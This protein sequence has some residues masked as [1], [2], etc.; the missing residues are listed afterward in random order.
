[1]GR[2]GIMDDIFKESNTITVKIKDLLLPEEE[3]EEGIMAGDKVYISPAFH[4]DF[5]AEEYVEAEHGASAVLV[6]VRYQNQLWGFDDW[7]NSEGERGINIAH[8][9]PLQQDIKLF[10][11]QCKT[12]TKYSKRE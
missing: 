1:M 9:E 4:M 6:V 10:K 2:T 8:K 5:I 7:V 11:V 3:M 12:V